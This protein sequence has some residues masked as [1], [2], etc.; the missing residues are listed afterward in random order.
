MNKR[1]SKQQKQEIVK[2]FLQGKPA[3]ELARER[4]VS[5]SSIYA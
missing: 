3:I 4:Q 2:Q 1:L 5:R